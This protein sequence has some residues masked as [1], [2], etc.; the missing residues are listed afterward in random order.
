MRKSTRTISIVAAVLAI[1]LG[2]ALAS[3][4]SSSARALQGSQVPI[5]ER[6][7]QSLAT[8]VDAKIDSVQRLFVRSDRCYK[9]RQDRFEHGLW[10]H[11]RYWR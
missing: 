1:T 2:G 10:K 6:A 11:F 7:M 4:H 9:P 5:L 3:D 8:T